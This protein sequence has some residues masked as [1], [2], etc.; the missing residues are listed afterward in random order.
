MIAAIRLRP[1]LAAKYPEVLQVLEEIVA[2]FNS[3]PVMVGNAQITSG[4][5]APNGRVLGNIGDLYV[6]RSGSTSTTLYVKESGTNTKT[7]WVAK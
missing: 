2:A 7:G 5:I 6:N 4:T 3:Q 1:E